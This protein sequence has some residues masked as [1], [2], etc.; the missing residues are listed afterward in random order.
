[1]LR[2]VPRMI[3]RAK[4]ID[5]IVDTT[6]AN[7]TGLMTI[8]PYYALVGMDSANLWRVFVSFWTINWVTSFSIV[9]V[10]KKFR[11]KFPHRGGK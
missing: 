4:V 5:Y 6:V 1:M 7:I 8:I 9:W 3:N 10:L 11:E 2:R